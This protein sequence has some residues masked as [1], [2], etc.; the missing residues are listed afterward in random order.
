MRESGFSLPAAGQGRAA[1]KLGLLLA[2]VAGA[3]GFLAFTHR[4]VRSPSRS[5]DVTSIGV[6]D[7]WLVVLHHDGGRVQFRP[8]RWSVLLGATAA[9]AGFALRRIARAERREALGAAGLC[10]TCG[11]DLRATPEA[12]GALLNRCPECGAA[13]TPKPSSPPAPPDRPAGRA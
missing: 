4:S 7:P 12:G 10:P 13:E 2:M 1:A 6:A 9:A 8:L 11:Y 5:E 3:G